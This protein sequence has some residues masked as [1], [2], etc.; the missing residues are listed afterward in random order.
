MDIDTIFD[1][2]EEQLDNYLKSKN[3]TYTVNIM[4]KKRYLVFYYA[5]NDN[6]LNKEA[7]SYVNKR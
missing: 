5:N 4:K 2:D 3:N 6:Q 1:L 7:V